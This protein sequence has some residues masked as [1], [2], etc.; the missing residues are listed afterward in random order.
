VTLDATTNFPLRP[1][2]LTKGT[3]GGEIKSKANAESGSIAI[4]VTALGVVR[5]VVMTLTSMPVTVVLKGSGCGSGKSGS[6]ARTFCV[7]DWQEA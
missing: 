2:K 3:V 6:P 4:R 1:S 7:H 5:R